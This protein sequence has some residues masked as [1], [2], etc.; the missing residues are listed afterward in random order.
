MTKLTFLHS[1]DIHGNLES[2]A[3]LTTIARRE[4]EA[5]ESQGRTVFRWDAGDAF[6]RKYP[7]C[8]L[9]RGQSLAP[10]LAASGVTVQTVGNDIGV[11]YGSTG[12]TKLVSAAAYT[13]LAANLRLQDGRLLPGVHSTLLY[14]ASTKVRLGLFGLTEPFDGYYSRFGIFTPD[15][16]QVARECVEELNRSGANFIVLLSHLGLHND[17]VL[18]E[19]VSGIKLIIGG[20]T[21]DVLPVGEYVNSTLIVQAGAFGQYLGRVD[22]TFNS[23]GH[24]M[25]ARLIPI[26][27]DTVP[28]AAVKAAV[29]SMQAELAIIGNEVI[30]DLAFPLP[31]DYFGDSPIAHFG[32]QALK[33][34]AGAEIGM[35]LGGAF[36][37]PLK[38]GAVTRIALADAVPGVLSPVT[39]RVTG[40][41]LRAALERSLDP[42]IVSFLHRGLRG[43]PLGVLGLSGIEVWIDPDGAVGQR[44]DEVKINGELLQVERIYH[45]A[46]TDIEVEDYAFLHGKGVTPL[47]GEFEYML[48]DVFRLYLE[49][50][51]APVQ[52]VQRVWHNIERLPPL[53]GGLN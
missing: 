52:G 48:E 42:T 20:H 4:R 34:R 37:S 53:S 22:V 13:H 40:A 21:H 39:S 3:R 45:V 43:S 18:A 8:R 31:L 30:S 47:D 19:E 10:V 36:H 16:I 7:E 14:E 44:V 23:S 49:K 9:T 50:S 41:A 11:V 46:H 28:D 32:A 5:A 29:I 33:D 2:L 1:N 38:A 35:V 51:T 26:P 12:L 6:D 15:T 17:R 27:L 25:S 24:N